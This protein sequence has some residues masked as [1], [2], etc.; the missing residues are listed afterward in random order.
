M[1][2]DQSFARLAEKS[3]FRPATQKAHIIETQVAK[4]MFENFDS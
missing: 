4:S 3:A 1:L 2:T